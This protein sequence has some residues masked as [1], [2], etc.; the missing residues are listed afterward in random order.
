[1]RSLFI[2]RLA[3]VVLLATFALPAASWHASGSEDDACL[4]VELAHDASNHRV[5]AASAISSDGVE[6]CAVCH[7]WQ[8]LR[9]VQSSVKSASVP[10][11][12]PSHAVPSRAFVDLIGTSALRGRAPPATL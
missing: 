1:V 8:S 12:S 5:E 9:V 3:A 10:D 4:T 7:W 11:A 2:R 6:H